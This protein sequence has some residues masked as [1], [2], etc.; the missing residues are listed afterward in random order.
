MKTFVVIGLGRFGQSV[1]LN[2]S[3]LGYDVLAIDKSQETIQSISRRVTHAVIGDATDEAVLNSLGVR[4]FDTAV[5]AIGDNMEASIMVTVLLKEL[6]VEQVVAKAQNPLHATVLDKVGADMVVFPE[7]D[8]GERLAHR[9]AQSNI[10]DYIEISPEYSIVEIALPESW[11][12]RT[13]KNL[14]IRAKYGLNI[15]AIKSHNQ[16]NISPDPDERFEKDD[17]IVVLGANDDLDK[18]H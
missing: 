2:L 15:I 18:I 10:L 5:V 9:L 8:M 12:G 13:I 16:I 4:N 17:I 7:I 3:E 1:A 14:D 6:G 11:V